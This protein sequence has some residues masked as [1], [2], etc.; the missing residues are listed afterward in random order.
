LRGLGV[1]TLVVTGLMTQTCV[2][3]TVRDA[4]CYDYYLAVPED[5]CG[6]TAQGAHDTSIRNMATFLRYQDAITT[7][8]RLCA[9][10]AAHGA[11]QRAPAPAAPA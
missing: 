2:E 3:T 7:S 10:W 9:I 5:C 4:A 1:K 8:E 11:A 6:S